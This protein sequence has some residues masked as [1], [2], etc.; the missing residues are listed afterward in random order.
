MLDSNVSTSNGCNR[1]YDHDMDACTTNHEKIGM[2]EHKVKTLLLAMKD[3]LFTKQDGTRKEELMAPS[4]RGNKG[5]AGLSLKDVAN[6]L[7]IING[8]ECST[9]KKGAT[10]HDVM[11]KIHSP[12]TTTSISLEKVKKGKQAIEQA[13]STKQEETQVPISRSYA[14]DYML[15]WDHR[16]K[17]V[18]KYVGAYTKKTMIKRSVWVPKALVTNS[19][20][21][22]S[23]WVPKSRA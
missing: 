15:T 4:T 18:I 2:L 9:W 21:P 5:K 13:K 16:G 22:K 3:D 20:G 17:M 11:N 14:C 6:P 12:S 23:I 10:L 8:R 1:C 7:V 19:Q